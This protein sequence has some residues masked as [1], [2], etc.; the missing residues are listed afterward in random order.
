MKY[1]IIAAGEGSRL[2]QEGVREPKPLVRI[3]GEMLIDR[4]IR[5]FIENEAESIIVA[6]RESMTEVAE[7]LE[8]IKRNVINGQR[9]SLECVGVDTPSSMHSMSAISDR[10]EDDTFCLTT[11]DTVFNEKAFKN[12]IAYLQT[13]IKEGNADGVMAVTDYIDDEKPLYV[14]TNDDMDITAFLDK[15]NGCRF[16]SAGI[17]GLTPN[18]IPVL[19]DC[20]NRGESRMRNFQRALLKNGMSLKA[21]NIGKAFDVDHASDILK[22]EQFLNKTE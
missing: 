10:L 21:V 19:R 8:K 12:Y 6:Y 18:A 9:I 22:A 11:V 17:Y 20:I 2:N 7:H 15:D 1:A 4:L 3:N 5:I 13:A 16:V 14:A